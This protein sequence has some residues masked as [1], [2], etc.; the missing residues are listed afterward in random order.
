MLTYSYVGQ[1]KNGKHHG[2]GRK[3]GANGKI[4]EGLFENDIYMENHNNISSYNPATD[5]IAK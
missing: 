1:W 2:Y 4:E 3:L 5:S